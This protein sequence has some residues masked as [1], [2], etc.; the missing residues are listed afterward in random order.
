LRRQESEPGRAT[1]CSVSGSPSLS[2]LAVTCRMDSASVMTWPCQTAV[3]QDV[4]CSHCAA[5]LLVAAPVA[6]QRFGGD[7]QTEAVH[8][9]ER[10]DAGAEEALGWRR[11]LEVRPTICD[12]LDRGRLAI[13]RQSSV[14]RGVSRS[15]RSAHG[16]GVQTPRADMAHAFLWRRLE[17]CGHARLALAGSRLNQLRCERNQADYDLG[18]DLAL[19]DAEAAVTSA[20]MIFD[21]LNGLSAE[22]RHLVTE[23]IKVY[24]RD[25][26]REPTWRKRPR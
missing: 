8:V 11:L 3:I 1:M 12:W 17:N 22:E 25:I 16:L 5:Q 13:R 26:L 21:T 19:K 4:Y 9:F 18:L 15:S 6:A 7:Q 24:E 14:L 20:A 10:H 23:T 2:R